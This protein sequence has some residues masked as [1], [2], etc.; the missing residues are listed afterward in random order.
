MVLSCR[1][2][3]WHTSEVQLQPCIFTKQCN[4]CATEVNIFHSCLQT[5]IFI[6]FLNTR[7]MM[8]SPVFPICLHPYSPPSFCSFWELSI[9]SV[10]LPNLSWCSDILF[11]C[12]ADSYLDF[13][14]SFSCNL[15]SV[16]IIFMSNRFL[17]HWINFV[18][19]FAPS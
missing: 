12:P 5:G 9:V 4:S 3:L 6:S 13:N 14:V 18:T 11:V 15:N 2:F 8:K 7:E 17:F 1:F 16:Y 10:F 19:G